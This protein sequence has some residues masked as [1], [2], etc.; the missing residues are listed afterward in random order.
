MRL[1]RFPRS[2]ALMV[3]VLGLVACGDDSS[4][5]ENHDV[6]ADGRLFLNGSE[7]SDGPLGLAAN[8]T[9]RVEV[10]FFNEAGDEI[11]GLEDEH[12]TRINV[13]PEGLV[14]VS[15]VQGENFQKDIIAGPEGGTGTY[16]IG[17]GHTAS[18]DERS[19]GLYDIVVIAST[20]AR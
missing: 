8:Q 18:A 4:P 13:L 7:V 14:T 1:T 6:P 20:S 2:L 5:D 11:T 3:L 15:S 10:K 19:F 9:V 17:Y 16:T 12:F